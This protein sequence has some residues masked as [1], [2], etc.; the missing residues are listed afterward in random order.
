MTLWEY[1]FVTF[2]KI[3]LVLL[4]VLGILIIK[5]VLNWLLK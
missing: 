4:V 1:M 5:S 2:T 3:Q